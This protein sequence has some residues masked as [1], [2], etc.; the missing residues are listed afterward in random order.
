MGA[1]RWG[2][3]HR[4]VALGAMHRRAMG[5]AF[6]AFCK[7]GGILPSFLHVRHGISV[8]LP[9][10]QCTASSACRAGDEGLVDTI[11]ATS[12]RPKP[13]KRN[14]QD[15]RLSSEKESTG[16][17][18][19]SKRFSKSLSKDIK[20]RIQE[21]GRAVIRAVGP[22]ATYQ[23]FKAVT[24][25]NELLQG[26]DLK[27]D[28]VLAAVPSF[29][30][31]RLNEQETTVT[32][33][34]CMLLP[35]MSADISI[36]ASQMLTSGPAKGQMSKMAAAIKSRIRESSRA[37]VLATG[38]RQI[39]TA[40]KAIVQ[41]G[42][43]LREDQGFSGKDVKMPSIAVMPRMHEFA[44]KTIRKGKE[45]G[46]DD[47]VTIGMRFDCVDVSDRFSTGRRQSSST[48]HQALPPWKA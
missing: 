5:L 27:G 32:F 18:F 11:W 23:A 6:L 45:R 2:A 25:A 30:P 21:S 40:T 29:R 19:A 48:S 16:D 35:Q 7:L 26:V 36:E 14:R 34:D 44:P 9:A 10:V 43:F 39:S 1:S 31:V 15:R 46:E 13:L 41:A 22:Q 17:L 12:S 47:P 8:R 24:A 20:N 3:M 38:S 37:V 42:R 33:L 4:R 28:Q